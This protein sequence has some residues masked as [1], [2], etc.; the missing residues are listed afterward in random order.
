M[1]K[2]DHETMGQAKAIEFEI[3][4]LL[5]NYPHGKCLSF[6]PIHVVSLAL[7]SLYTKAA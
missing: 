4:E 2:P 6:L 1:K 5:V 3:P 7:I